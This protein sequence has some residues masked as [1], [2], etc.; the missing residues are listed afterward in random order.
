M[1][2]LFNVTWMITRLFLAAAAS[3]FI[4][5]LVIVLLDDVIALKDGSG[6]TDPVTTRFVQWAPL[7]FV[8]GGVVI[9]MSVGTWIGGWELRWPLIKA[10]F[11]FHR[12]APPQP[13]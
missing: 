2:R 11:N 3:T 5:C 12:P 9:S 1:E 8:L 4:M 13:Q 7:L 10:V 6:T